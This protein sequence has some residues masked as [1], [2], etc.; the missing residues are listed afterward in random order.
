[1]RSSLKSRAAIFF[2]IGIVI[3]AAVLPN[4]SA[5]AQECE[6]QETLELGAKIYSENCAVCHGIDGQGRVGATLAKD[7]PSIRPDL[8]VRDTIVSG[9]P[10]LLMPAWS[11]ANGGPFEEDEID[12]LVCYILSWQTGGPPIIYPTPTPIAQLALTPPPGVSGDVVNGANIYNR[13]CAVCH[14]AEGEGRIGANL[15]KVWPSIRPDLR[16]RSVI[17]SG[18]EDTAMP[19]WSQANGGPLTNAEIDDTVAYILTFSTSPYPAPEVT[20]EPESGGVLTGWP[21]WL[22]GFI[23]FLLILAAI[24]Y[25]SRQNPSED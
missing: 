6:D 13:N 10:G 5:S 7:W 8:R 12:A 2:A 18:A 22:A 23:L 25:F 14:G 9:G 19:A 20:E 11:L 4:L 21:V 16:V 3:A 1:M 15:S 24:A 17:V